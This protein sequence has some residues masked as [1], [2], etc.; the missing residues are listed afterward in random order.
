MGGDGGEALWTCG[1]CDARF[2]L[3]QAN[4]WLDGTELEWIGTGVAEARGIEVAGTG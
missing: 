4:G 3:L 2:E 1:D